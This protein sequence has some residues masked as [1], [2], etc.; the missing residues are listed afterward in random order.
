MNL[1]I[2]QSARLPDFI[3]GGAPKCGTTSLH[4]ILSQNPAVGIPDDE[5]HFFDADDPIGHPDFL[6][7]GPDGLDWRDPNPGNLESLGWYAGRFSK[8]AG[9]ACLGEDSTIYL[10][11]EVAAERIAKMLPDVRLIF[12]LRNPVKRAYSQYWHLMTR[13]RTTCSFEKALRVHPS[14]ILGSTYAP[15]LRRYLEIFGPNRV[16]IVLFE[17][18]LADQQGFI[19]GITDF[20]DV[21]RMQVT[22]GNAWFNRTYYPCHLGMQRAVNLL[23]SRIVRQQYRNHFNQRRGPRERAR[24]KLH[25]YWFR[26]AHPVFLKST[27]QPPMAPKTQRFLEQHLSARNGGLSTLLGRDLSAVWPRF[28]G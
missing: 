19:D 17:D 12:M 13:G 24:N 15:H 16:R 2:D 1:R 18:F 26:Y 14:V 21:P 11:S 27:K 28:T 9:C 23:S 8:L 6:F 22:S 7:D 4:F 25:Y 5:I 20:L 10:Q 3:I